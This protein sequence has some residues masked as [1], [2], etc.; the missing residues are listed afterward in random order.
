[1]QVAMD[2]HVGPDQ[3]VALAREIVTEAAVSSRYVYLPKPVVV[4]VSQVITQNYVA[5]QLK[6]RAYVLDT[7][8]EKAFV[9]DVNLRVLEAFGD[10]GVLPPAILHRTVE[11]MARPRKPALKLTPA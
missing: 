6:L 2:F 7:K 5:V 1:M 4:L 3:D 10:H 11:D 8:Y 9:T